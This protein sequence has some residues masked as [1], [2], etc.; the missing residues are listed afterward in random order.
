MVRTALMF[1]ASMIEREAIQTLDH[2]LLVI[3][4]AMTVDISHE[5]VDD[6][7]LL[8]DPLRVFDLCGGLLERQ[9]ASE[10]GLIAFPHYSVYEYLTA[11]PTGEGPLKQ[12]HF[13]M[14]Q[15]RTELAEIFLRYQLHVIPGMTP[16][17]VRRHQSSSAELPRTQEGQLEWETHHQ[18]HAEAVRSAVLH[19]C[20]CDPQLRFEPHV[21]TTAGFQRLLVTLWSDRALFDAWVRL[22]YFRRSIATDIWFEALQLYLACLYDLPAQVRISLAQGSKPCAPLLILEEYIPIWPAA[23]SAAR[24]A[25]RHGSCRALGALLDG[26]LDVDQR[27]EGRVDD[28]YFQRSQVAALPLLWWAVIDMQPE[29]CALLLERGAEVHRSLE[30]GI[31]PVRSLLDLLFCGGPFWF[32]YLSMFLAYEG[33]A[34][35]IF[36][37]LV[38]CGVD[39]EG[40][41]SNLLLTTL[42]FG[43]IEDLERL[44]VD[45]RSV[46]HWTVTQI[47]W[48]LMEGFPTDP[49]ALESLAKRNGHF[50]IL[51]PTTILGDPSAMTAQPSCWDLAILAAMRV[52]G[53]LTSDDALFPGLSLSE[54]ARHPTIPP[55]GRSRGRHSETYLL[56]NGVYYTE[57]LY[58]DPSKIMYMLQLQ[59]SALQPGAPR[60][61]FADLV[62]AAAAVTGAMWIKR[63]QNYLDNLG[64]MDDEIYASIAEYEVCGAGILAPW[65]GRSQNPR[66]LSRLVARAVCFLAIVCREA[67]ADGEIAPVQPDSAYDLYYDLKDNFM[68]KIWPEDLVGQA[69]ESE[70]LDQYQTSK[71]GE[72]SDI[73]VERS[74]QDPLPIG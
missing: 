72:L 68:A 6:G 64:T 45:E 14:E 61:S 27:I 54:V 33:K 37:L 46:H 44:P 29:V 40:S 66:I 22:I 49:R 43:T 67:E 28:R 70:Y 17:D 13:T 51:S 50:R 58:E 21:T 63:S 57:E 25:I 60:K 3:C 32:D 71:F 4:G 10:K 34:R 19:H 23:Q 39:W 36:R 73:Y 56:H 30:P 69:A 52:C 12:F 65:R 62:G 1:A 31:V 38:G 11:G 47:H 24:A 20:G 53:V 18:P 59:Q 2:Y 15:A 55:K 26:H 5:L 7:R 42:Y 41:S 48:A 35:R 74:K 9:I 16:D 8:P